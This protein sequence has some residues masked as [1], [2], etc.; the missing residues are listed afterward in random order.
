MHRQ[1]VKKITVLFVCNGW[2]QDSRAFEPDKY[3]ALTWYV[4]YYLY[5]YNRGTLQSPTIEI[6]FDAYFMLGSVM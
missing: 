6:V 2:N 4:P 3:S 5:Y 1:D